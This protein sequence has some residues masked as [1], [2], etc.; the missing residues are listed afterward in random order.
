MSYFLTTETLASRLQ[1]IPFF[2]TQLRQLE[3]IRLSARSMLISFP[4]IRCITRVSIISFFL[5][6]ASINSLI[7]AIG[8]PR[9]NA[10]VVVKH[11]P[12]SRPV[13]SVGMI[14]AAVTTNSF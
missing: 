8:W 7:G 6:I 2:V 13:L 9:L 14:L 1:L 12:V 11:S 4:M 5:K 3:V 10:S